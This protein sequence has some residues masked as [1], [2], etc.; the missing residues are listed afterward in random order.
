MVSTVIEFDEN[1]RIAWQT[2]PPIGRFIAGGRIWRYELE[3]VAG[4]TRVRESWDI[5]QEKMKALVT[6]GKAREK[7]RQSMAKTLENIE[8]ICANEMG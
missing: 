2:W 4:G 8:K 6:I 7:T 5:S 3:P 1:R